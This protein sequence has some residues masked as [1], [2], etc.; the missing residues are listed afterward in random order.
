MTKPPASKEPRPFLYLKPARMPLADESVDEFGCA[1]LDASMEPSVPHL[2]RGIVDFTI[3]QQ[4]ARSP[5]PQPIPVSVLNRRRR[6]ARAWLRA[7]AEGRRDAAT[8]HAAAGQWLPILCGT[9]PEF[10]HL[11]RRAGALIEYVRGA[12]TATIFAQSRESLLGEAR[13]LHVLESTLRVHFA[14]VLEAARGRRR[15]R[16]LAIR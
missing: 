14:A 10:V 15:Q 1:W 3:A 6:A 9:G 7:L 5:H 13:A 2:V 12:V 8:R 16:P 11:A 4:N